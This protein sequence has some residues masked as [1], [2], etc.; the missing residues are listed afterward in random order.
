MKG[1]ASAAVEGPGLK[2]SCREVVSESA[3]Q[4]PQKTPA[5]W[6]SQVEWSL[7]ELRRQTVCAA[8]D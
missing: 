4:L 1:A 8:E 6:R 7:S 2:G 3:A 5:L